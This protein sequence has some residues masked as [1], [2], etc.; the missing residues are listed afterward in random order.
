MQFSKK[1]SN[2]LVAISRRLLLVLHICLH[3]R[4]ICF[5]KMTHGVG[6]FLELVKCNMMNSKDYLRI[7][8][9]PMEISPNFIKNTAVWCNLEL[10]KLP[11]FLLA[12]VSFRG[13][14]FMF[15]IGTVPNVESSYFDSHRYPQ[16]S[17]RIALRTRHATRTTGC[18]STKW[19]RRD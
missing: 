7:S 12:R 14:R 11:H 5:P 18:R 19:P 1:D 13:A 4:M 16:A 9:T 17:V 6:T 3:T 8:D 15:N 2:N 10:K